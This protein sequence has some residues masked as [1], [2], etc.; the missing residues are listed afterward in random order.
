MK[1]SVLVGFVVM[2]LAAAMFLVSNVPVLAQSED[3]DIKELKDRLKDLEKKENSELDTLRK[4]IEALERQRGHRTPPREEVEELKKTVSELKTELDGQNALS[5]RI[6]KFMEKHKLKAG[7]RMQ[8]WYQY[9]E[10]GKKAGTKDLHD[11]MIRRFYFYLKG[12]VTPKMGFFGHIAADRIGQEGLDRSGMG[13][14]T[15][16]AVRDAWIYYNFCEAF[17]VQL[18]RM[19]VPFTRNYG[20]TSTFALLPLELPFN[21]GGVRGGIFYASKVGRDDSAVFWGNPLDGK[22]QYRLGV[23]EGVEG[24]D[25][26]DDNL[27]FTGRVC[28]NLLEPETSW[29]N[30]GTYLGKKKVLALGAGLHSQKD[31]TLSGRPGE[32]NFGWTTDI[33]FDYPVGDGAVTAEAAYIDMKDVTQTLS[34]SWL[35]SGDD[36]EMYYIQGGYLLPG[37]IGPGTLQPYFRYERLNVDGKPDTVFPG[38]GVN[39]FIK[40]HGA[41][42]TL[43]WTQIDQKTNLAAPSGNY[44]GK[45]Q[46]VITFQVTVGF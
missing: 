1:K 38:V 27:R 37:K 26:P 22:I 21:Q 8:G 39:Y 16:I 45:D 44:S 31:L 36:A 14:G 35:T 33:F 12:E 25:N 13:L 4:R 43:D 11:F 41:K 6:N 18:G 42:L 46:N 40:G 20:T 2:S 15:G 34:Y 23:S 3:S 30:K 17:K 10:D 9:V 7:L 32:D 19:Y 5:A 28:F 24:G 29:F